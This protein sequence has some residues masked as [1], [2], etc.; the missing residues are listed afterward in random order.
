VTAEASE[1]PATVWLPIDHHPA[2]RRADNPDGVIS[3]DQAYA[4]V[5][6]GRVRSLFV[7]KRKILLHRDA[8]DDLARSGR[9]D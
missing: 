4:L 7:S 8:L 6:S 9:P 2:V 3:R 1:A 5:R